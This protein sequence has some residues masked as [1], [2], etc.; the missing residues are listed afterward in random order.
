MYKIPVFKAEIDAGVADLVTSTSSVAYTCSLEVFEGESKHSL[1][2]ALAAELAK[3]NVED[4]T[5]FNIRD[6]L[7]STGWNKNSDV[8]DRYETWAARHTSDDKPFNIEHN[9]LDIIGHIVGSLTVD[10]DKNEIDDTVAFDDLPDQFHILNHTVIYRNIGGEERKAF[11]EKTIAEIQN[12]EWSVSMEALFRGF[13]YALIGSDNSHQIIQRNEATAFL[14]KNLRQYGGEGIYYD[15][16]TA[17]EYKIGRVMRNMT[18][19]GKGLVRKPANPNSYIFSTASVFRPSNDLLVYQVSEEV[20]N[21]NKENLMSEI[22]TQLSQA[23]S[24]IESL[25]VEIEKLKSKDVEAQVASLTASVTEKTKEASDLRVQLDTV[26][27]TVD[28][29]TKRAESAETALSEA[30]DKLTKYEAEKIV[31]ARKAILA[32]KGASAEIIDELVAKLAPLS[33]EAFASTVSVISK[34]WVVEA[35]KTK[36]EKEIQTIDNAVAGDTTALATAG[37]TTEDTRSLAIE[38]VGS[39]LKT[40]S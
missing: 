14:T 28:S 4:I 12:G 39:H 2:P 26:S 21:N 19:C 29:L 8:F 38:W 30:T 24:T 23:N 40:N 16:A 27:A 22:E 32:E 20:V 35:P 9:Q 34:S 11:I 1:S 17:S 10:N 5:I 13:D 18:F 6:L 25:K 36:T 33:D 37:T 3:A 15:K 31:V 7:V